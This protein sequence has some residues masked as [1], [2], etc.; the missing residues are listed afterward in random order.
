MVKE[1]SVHLL[2]HVYLLGQIWYIAPIGK[3]NFM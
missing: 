2:D 3:F 1:I